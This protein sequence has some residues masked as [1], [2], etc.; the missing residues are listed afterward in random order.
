MRVSYLKARGNAAKGKMKNDQ[1]LKLYKDGLKLSKRSDIL[2]RE[3][4]VLYTNIS[5]VYSDLNNLQNALQNATC[6]TELDSTWSKVIQICN[7]MY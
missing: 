1:A 2:R 4:A 3:T 5:T 6:A 7:K